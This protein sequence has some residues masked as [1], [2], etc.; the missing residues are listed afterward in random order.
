MR[1]WSDNLGPH[2]Q[3]FAQKGLM[4]NSS[5]SSIISNRSSSYRAKTNVPS[6]DNSPVNRSYP[7]PAR[8]NLLSRPLPSWIKERPSPAPPLPPVFLEVPKFESLSALIYAT[9]LSAVAP[10]TH[11]TLGEQRKSQTN[12]PSSFPVPIPRVVSK[13]SAGPGQPTGQSIIVASEQSEVVGGGTQRSRTKKEEVEARRGNEEWRS[14]EWQ[15]RMSVRKVMVLFLTVL[16]LL[17]MSRNPLLLPSRR[18]SRSGHGQ[19]T[20]ARVMIPVVRVR[21]KAK[22]KSV[23][24]R[25][26]LARAQTAYILSCRAPVRPPN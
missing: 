11:A 16:K 7:R 25:P 26:Y 21:Q 1:K 15:D 20:V 8:A 17:I 10:T 19:M 2:E 5:A 13:G 14:G 23:T 4:V 12:P 3:G 6:V 18:A 9:K 22:I 24:P